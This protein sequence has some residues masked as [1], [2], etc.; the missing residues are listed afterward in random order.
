MVTTHPA[1]LPCVDSDN[2]ADGEMARE[3]NNHLCDR[4]IGTSDLSAAGWSLSRIEQIEALSG[5]PMSEYLN[6]QDYA[7]ERS[8]RIEGQIPA[9]SA[10]EATGQYSTDNLPKLKTGST[11]LTG[12]FVTSRPD[13]P[14]NESRMPGRISQ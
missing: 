3:L 5:N 9:A 14:A 4:I 12:Y 13:D 7:N 11:V 10:V 6:H 2:I 8:T 1:A